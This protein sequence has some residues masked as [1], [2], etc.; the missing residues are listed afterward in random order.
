MRI[1]PLAKR[2]ILQCS[3]QL[4]IDDSHYEGKNANLFNLDLSNIGA[5]HGTSSANLSH[6]TVYTP[7]T[8]DAVEFQS[9]AEQSLCV[10]YPLHPT[11]ATDTNFV[12]RVKTTVDRKSVKERGEDHH[13]HHIVPG[14]TTNRSGFESAR[15]LP[16]FLEAGTALLENRC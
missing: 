5:S 9:A 4:L 3:I 12:F 15:F 7:I 8:V 14:K 16:W 2:S 13:S 11:I 10:R 1:Q 6:S